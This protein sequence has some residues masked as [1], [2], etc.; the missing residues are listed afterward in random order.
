MTAP[1]YAALVIVMAIALLAPI[2]L[3]RV[4]ESAGILDIPNSRSSHGHPVLRGG[5]LAP[6]LALLAAVPLLSR[7]EGRVLAVVAIGLAAAAA[8]V[9]LFDDVRALPARTRLAIHVTLGAAGGVLVVRL[10]E[11][12]WWWAVVMMIVVAA[13]INMVNFMD[14]INL[15]SGL[16]GGVAGAALALAGFLTATP[17]LTVG[18]ALVA[19][20]FL[21]FLPWNVMGS[22]MFLGDVGSYLLGAVLAMLAVAAIASDVPPL[23]VLAPFSVYVTDTSVTV[24]RRMLRK[25]NILEAHRSHVYQVMVRSGRSHVHVAFTVTAFSVVA[26]GMGL[27]SL[28]DLPGWLCLAG[29]LLINAAYLALGARAQPRVLN[30]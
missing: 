2:P 11:S 16:H 27:L 10:T 17:F 24:V 28:N 22:R 20:A 9:G 29:V 19:V 15:I 6:L 21:S 18:G 7:V 12:P 25:E 8:M 1:D 14:G 5:G 23:A 4:L 13:Y 3:R 26:A 30:S